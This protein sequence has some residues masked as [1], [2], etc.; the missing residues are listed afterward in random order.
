MPH[1]KFEVKN[2]DFDHLQREL[3]EYDPKLGEKP[4]LVVGNKIDEENADQYVKEFNKR[5]PQIPLLPISALLDE[6]L[7]ELKKSLLEKLS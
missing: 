6:G 1:N 4:F 5:F 7:P 2:Y 3:L